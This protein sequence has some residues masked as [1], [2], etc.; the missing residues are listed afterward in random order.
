M[1]DNTKNTV[2]Y[3]FERIFH[4]FRIFF[5]E[6]FQDYINTFRINFHH[7]IIRLHWLSVYESLAFFW[8]NADCCSHIKN[9]FHVLFFQFVSRSFAAIWFDK[10]QSLRMRF[11]LF[12]CESLM[13]MRMMLSI[14]FF[15]ILS[16]SIWNNTMQ[17]VINFK[18]QNRSNKVTN[19][20][21]ICTFFVCTTWSKTR[22]I[23]SFL[24][25]ANVCE[26]KRFALYWKIIFVFFLKFVDQR[27]HYK[28]VFFSR[29]SSIIVFFSIQ[30]S[31]WNTKFKS[32]D[33]VRNQSFARDLR[34]I[35]S[36][37]W[38]MRTKSLNEKTS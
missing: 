12:V 33:N 14:V 35:L 29:K 7:S 25:F 36:K 32:I 24:T 3:S 23:I 18:L 6:A 1:F 15:E 20:S 10:M 31:V 22:W 8:T 16:R 5:F 26:K 28:F 17:N 30:D 4:W 21:H 34:R 11:K 37:I 38:K 13:H 27:F 19:F 9:I 2:K